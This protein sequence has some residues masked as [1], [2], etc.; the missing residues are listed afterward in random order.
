[1]DVHQEPVLRE[2]TFVL[3]VDFR[4]DGTSLYQTAVSLQES[5]AA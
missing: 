3:T 5:A 4:A 2:G 1:V